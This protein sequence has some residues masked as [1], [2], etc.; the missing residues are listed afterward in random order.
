[1]K[2]RRS[3]IDSVLRARRVQEELAR[4]ALAHANAD[5]RRADD[6]YRDEQSR[7]E[8]LSEVLGIQDAEAFVANRLSCELA[9][10]TLGAARMT[11]DDAAVAAAMNHAAWREAAQRV[12]SL[13]RLDARRQAEDALEAMRA[14]AVEIDEIVTSRWEFASNR[15]PVPGAG[16]EALP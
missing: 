9:A 13:E 2:R 11:R 10:A 6:S 12:A 8:S 14:E 3:R 7:Y 15:V 16:T 5:L 4:Q 1:M